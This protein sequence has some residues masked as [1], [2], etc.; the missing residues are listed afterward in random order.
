MSCKA[1]FDILEEERNEAV[2]R[3]FEVEHVEV[4]CF[5][6]HRQI[7]E[8]FLK[9]FFRQEFAE[10][11]SNELM[12]TIRRQDVGIDIDPERPKIEPLN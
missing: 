2:K 10:R 8:K 3:L 5:E 11:R 9:L 12:R 1:R 7:C 6:F 4:E